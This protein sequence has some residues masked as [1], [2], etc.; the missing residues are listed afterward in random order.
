M[1][2]A[3]Y[4]VTLLPAECLLVILEAVVEPIVMGAF[5][6]VRHNVGAC[7]VPFVPEVLAEDLRTIALRGLPAAIPATLLGVG[8]RALTRSRTVPQ[9]GTHTA[10][11]RRRPVR[12]RT[13]LLATALIVLVAADVTAVALALPGYQYVWE[14]WIRG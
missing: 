11:G 6:L 12:T 5:S 1:P 7:S 8:I 14:T 2:P 13:W 10:G 9:H 3:L 4:G